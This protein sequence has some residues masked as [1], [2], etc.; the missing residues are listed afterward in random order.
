MVGLSGLIVLGV[1]PCIISLYTR[2]SAPCTRSTLSCATYLLCR[3]SPNSAT[4]SPSS[5]STQ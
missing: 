1:A 3:L 5:G 2:S 4:Q